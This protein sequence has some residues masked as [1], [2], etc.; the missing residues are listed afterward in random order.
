VYRVKTHRVQKPKKKGLQQN[1]QLNHVYLLASLINQSR[2]TGL[3]NVNIG[4]AQIEKTR[5]TNM[6]M[7]SKLTTAL[8]DTL[9]ILSFQV[10]QDACLFPS[11]FL[12]ALLNISPCKK[13]EKK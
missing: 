1:I 4:H 7:N 9:F 8:V 12:I 10:W 13:G 11:L 2:A 3:E 6:H 5:I